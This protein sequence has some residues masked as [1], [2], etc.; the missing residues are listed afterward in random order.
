MKNLKQLF[1]L[2]TLLIGCLTVTAQNIEDLSFG[3]D[4]TFEIMTWNIE[5]F[6]KND[7]STI[8]YVTE[9]IRALDIDLIA[10]QEISDTNSFKQ[11]LN[12]LDGYEVYFKSDWYAGLT[13]LYKSEII[14]IN[15]I[16]EIYKTSPYWSA[17]PR[18]P[19]V[20]D[21]NFMNKN[22]QAINN[23][24][25]CCG[26][27]ILDLNNPNDEETRRYYAS[28]LLK[29]YIDA[30]LPEKNVFVVGDLNDDI[31]EE[32]ENN[33]FQTIINDSENYVFTDAEIANG[34]SSDWS[35]P[36]Y[37][38]HLD[39]ILITNELFDEFEDEHS[40]IETIRIDDYIT[41]EW[42]TYE[43]NI[44]D[45]RPTAL[46]FKPN[47]N[48]RVDYF[49]MESFSFHNSP[50]PFA[51]FTYFSFSNLKEKSKIEIYNA[52]G[53]KIYSSNISGGQ[54][55]L[56]WCADGLPDGIYL[57]MLISTKNLVATTKLIIKK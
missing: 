25:K 3:T 49:Q 33:V 34:I 55:T 6:P 26:D 17:F 38:S 9:I 48:P 5:N 29:D 41:G 28:N 15:E 54:K 14:E 39:H 11:I 30:F 51:N 47:I 31:A 46:K 24:F 42:W 40:I 13:Y 4:T 53:N 32:Q 12:E 10:L 22:Y 1:I 45:H 21:F 19:Q 2:L 44:S 8:D 20:I 23:H 57:A 37:P 16:Y 27:G 18:S 50:N 7:Q 36:T 43:Q 56:R 52:L 35:Y